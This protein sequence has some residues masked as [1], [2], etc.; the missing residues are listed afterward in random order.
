MKLRKPIRLF[1]YGFTV[2][3]LVLLIYQF[4]YGKLFPYS[5][6]VFGFTNHEMKHTNIYIQNGGEFDDF[7][8]IDTLL[9]Q[10]EEFH[11]MKFKYKPEI[12]IFADSGSFIGRSM[13]KAR[14]CVYYNSRLFIS[15]WAICEADSDK[16]SLDIYLRHELSHSLI[17]QH[18][19]LVN[20]YK[21]PEW[22]LEGIA[23]YSSNQMGSS[24]YPGKE[25]VYR[26]IKDG[27]FMPP[28]LFKTAGEDSVSLNVKYRITFMTSQF[29]CIVDYLVTT[30]GKEKL[31]SFMKKLMENSNN[32]EVFLSIYGFDFSKVVEDFK[33]HVISN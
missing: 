14:F 17:F 7:M 24:F 10:V 30:Y 11:K 23:V 20:A 4:A 29:A 12:Y 2:I 6:V 33:K 25:E 18:T 8:K 13:S 26:N 3:I 22:L 21:Y 15:P 19:G 31:I 32:N 16:I 9:K 5:P 27:N 28:H 1:V